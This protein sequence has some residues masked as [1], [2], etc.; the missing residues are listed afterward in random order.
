MNRAVRTY[1]ETADWS[2]AYVPA[3][4][5]PRAAAHS[6]AHSYRAV[7]VSGAGNFAYVHESFHDWR[8]AHRRL[9]LDDADLGL[10]GPAP[11]WLAQRRKPSPE[12]TGSREWKRIAQQPRPDTRSQPSAH[13]AESARQRGSL[14]T[15]ETR[16]TLPPEE[17]VVAIAIA[18]VGPASRSEMYGPS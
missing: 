4:V 18:M 6:S 12:E 9:D 2:L 10:D 13:T 3:R 8:G 14:T 11:R 1:S 7:S 17:P 15:S 16:N 5:R